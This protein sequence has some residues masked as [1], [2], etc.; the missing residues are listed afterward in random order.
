M[1]A[2]SIPVSPA[3]IFRIEGLATPSPSVDEE[4]QK[5]IADRLI[6]KTTMMGRARESVQSREPLHRAVSTKAQPV[7]EP[8]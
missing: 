8:P 4:R 3:I 5:E 6:G 1:P 2:P 7:G